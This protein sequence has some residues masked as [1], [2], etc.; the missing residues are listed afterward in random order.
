MHYIIFGFISGLRVG[1]EFLTGKQLQKTDKFV[2]L[3]DLGIVRIAYV[4]R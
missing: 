1:I 3:L 2:I 4:Y